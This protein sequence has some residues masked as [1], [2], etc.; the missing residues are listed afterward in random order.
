VNYEPGSNALK[1]INFDAERL[2]YRTGA[3]QVRKEE[4]ERQQRERERQVHLTELDGALAKCAE[5]ADAGENTAS[6]TTAERH[7]EFLQ[8]ELIRRGFTVRSKGGTGPYSGNALD[9]PVY[10]DVEWRPRIGEV[11]IER[12]QVEERR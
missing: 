4:R 11:C 2:G 10:L 1:H 5:R 9:R 6:I 7:L 12:D 8:A 3:G